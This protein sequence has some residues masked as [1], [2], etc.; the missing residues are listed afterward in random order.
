MQDSFEVWSQSTPETPRLNKHRQRSKLVS[1]RSACQV[2]FHSP[3]RTPLWHQI[4]GWLFL[5]NR[6]PRHLHPLLSVVVCPTA[7]A[8]EKRQWF[9]IHSQ[10]FSCFCRGP[11]EKTKCFTMNVLQAKPSENVLCC[12]KKHAYGPCALI[13]TVWTLT[14]STKCTNMLREKCGITFNITVFGTSV[15]A[16]SEPY[17]KMNL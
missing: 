12:L 9:E 11:R 15:W 8:W 16:T 10:A 5:L 17:C 4:S 3:P 7:Q 6:T 13:G 2:A 1:F 14:S